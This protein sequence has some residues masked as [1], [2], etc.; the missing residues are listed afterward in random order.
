[1]RKKFGW[2]SLCYAILLLMG[3]ALPHA[4]GYAQNLVPVS[5]QPSAT[6]PA[7]TG[8]APTQDYRLG[9]N[10]KVTIGVYGEDELS[11]E[12]TVGPSGTISLPLIGEVVAKGRTVD[13][14]R[15]ELQQRLSA[16]FINNPTISVTI[17]GF[18]NFY[19]L[20]EV[21][22]P[23]EY[24][25]ETGMT[26]TQ[27]VAEAAGFTYRARK[28]Y[29]FVRHEGEAAETRVPITPDLQVRPG[30]TIRIGERYF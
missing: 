21:T 18:R 29:A 12:Y 22:R 1:M 17:S 28:K 10:D 16:G 20:G 5:A 25:Y 8:V 14:L 24:A 11:R 19:V 2:Q 6:P 7:P 26:I 4:A 15:S 13:T 23:G 3:A 30:D 27:A 9:P